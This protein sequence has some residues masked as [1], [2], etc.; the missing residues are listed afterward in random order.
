MKSE[1]DSIILPQTRILYVAFDV[2]PAPKGAAI[3]IDQ[4]ARAL[5]NACQRVD[6]VTVAPGLSAIGEMEIAP[7]LFHTQLPAIGD[8]LVKRV[9]HF[10][11]LL[12]CWLSKQNLPFD[13]IQFRSPFEGLWISLRKNELCKKLVFE[14]NGLPSIELKYRYDALRNDDALMAKLY[15]QEQT[16]LESA[17]LIVTPSRVTK[18]YLALRDVAKGRIAVVRNGVDL[19]TFH[20]QQPRRWMPGTAIDITYFGTLAPWQGIDTM[21]RAIALSEYPTRLRIIASGKQSMINAAT[22]LAAKLGVRDQIF[23][24]PPTSQSQLAEILHGSHAM[25]APLTPI[26]RNILQGCCPLKVIEGMA[27]GVAVITSDLEVTRELSDSTDCLF[28]TKPASE[29]QI[30]QRLLEVVTDYEKTVESCRLAR[31]IIEER[32]TWSSAG[33]QLVQALS[34]LRTSN[35][36]SRLV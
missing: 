31:R 7:R 32:H 25:L 36:Y 8:D 4:F 20:F 34:S 3:H 5:A 21:I 22:R 10:R 17:D 27:S 2:V 18:D 15:G 16:C 12:D 19:E 1:S 28:F 33:N 9:T 11:R 14:V 13:V 30:A 29:R 23:L 26:D 24:E 6:L 35:E